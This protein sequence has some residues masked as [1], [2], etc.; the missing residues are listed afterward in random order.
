MSLQLPVPWH[1]A[2][3]ALVADR[4]ITGVLTSCSPPPEHE[5]GKIVSQATEALHGACAA[6][7]S[8]HVSTWRD[9]GTSGT[10]EVESRPRSRPPKLQQSCWPPI[11]DDAT[12]H[13]LGMAHNLVFRGNTSHDNT[14]CFLRVAAVRAAY[15][16][17]MD[18][19]A[20]TALLE[21]PWLSFLTASIAS[22]VEFSDA[23][24][25]AAYGAAVALVGANFFTRAW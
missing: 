10:M 9:Q 2:A 1:D 19:E 18:E 17:S 11:S 7:V 5:G 25:M 14:D 6:V 20:S 21:E 3:N 12:T 22:V 23:T 16:A 15:L 4:I 24:L 8:L 13:L